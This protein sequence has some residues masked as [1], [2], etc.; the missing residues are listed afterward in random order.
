MGHTR[1]GAVK[2]AVAEF[3]DQARQRQLQQDIASSE[4]GTEDSSGTSDLQAEG[5]SSLDRP[6]SDALAAIIGG[7]GSSSSGSKNP[8][9]CASAGGTGTAAGPARAIRGFV[10]RLLGALG[11][12]EATE[13]LCAHRIL[14]VGGCTAVQR[15]ACPSAEFLGWQAGCLRP[16][17]G[18]ST[19]PA[20]CL[21][22]CAEYHL[23]LAAAHCQHIHLVYTTPQLP[24]RP[25]LPAGTW[26]TWTTQSTPSCPPSCQLSSRSCGRCCR[27]ATT[28]PR[29]GC[30][31]HAA[32]Q[33]R[34]QTTTAAAAQMLCTRAWKRRLA[35]WL[36]Q[37]RHRRQLW[38]HPRLSGAAVGQRA[39]HAAACPRM[40]ACPV[41]WRR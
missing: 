23:Q 31:P 29:L 7:G 6:L 14:Q 19:S 41:W 24:S 18:S 34:R 26:S 21:P 4:G 17:L 35:L 1:C 15:S 10:Q 13:T 3:V 8:A 36:L 32:C 27:A 37:Q 33:S 40:K 11:G 2:A 30:R 9:N 38:L 16:S 20:Q 5:S 22:C 25:P 28:P 39:P 12:R